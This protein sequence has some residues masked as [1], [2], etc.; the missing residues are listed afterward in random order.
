MSRT[1]FDLA[2]INNQKELQTLASHHGDMV[3]S[4][5][6][7][8]IWVHSGIV[9]SK[10]G[11]ELWKIFCQKYHVLPNGDFN[12]ENGLFSSPPSYLFQEY[13]RG[14]FRPRAVF[15]DED[16]HT[17]NVVKNSSIGSIFGDW[18]FLVTKPEI[19]MFVE[20]NQKIFVLGTAS[21]PNFFSRFPKSFVFSVFPDQLCSSRNHIWNCGESLRLNINQI[22]FSNDSIFQLLNKRGVLSPSFRNVNCII[23]HY[24]ETVHSIILSKHFM[25]SANEIIHVAIPSFYPILPITIDSPSHFDPNGI[26][27]DIINTDSLSIFPLKDLQLSSIHYILRGSLPSPIFE[28][29]I[30]N[31]ENICYCYKDPE[32]PVIGFDTS[33]ES[34]CFSISSISYLDNNKAIFDYILSHIDK[35]LESDYQRF[36]ELYSDLVSQKEYDPS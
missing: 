18:H 27:I 13:V 16:I 14:K 15:I 29:V 3:D 19:D 30:S 7:N 6:Y 8:S 35:Y 32:F 9:G 34:S 5:Q 11:I 12:S 24:I 20:Q 33:F 36:S 22:I 23:A 28:E 10:I 25:L 26:S 21:N 1:L 2:V 31:I 4:L 17:K